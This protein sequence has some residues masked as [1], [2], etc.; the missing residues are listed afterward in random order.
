MEFFN[1]LESEVC[2]VMSSEI[3]VTI[4]APPHRDKHVAEIS[5]FSD[6]APPEGYDSSIYPIGEVTVDNGRLEFE[7]Y[8]NSENDCRTFN[9]KDLVNAI[10]E[11]MKRLAEI[12][13]QYMEQQ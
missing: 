7:I 12:Y 11:G 9:C 13:P 1:T 3:K 4:C 10:N 8:V 5:F 2:L 6:D